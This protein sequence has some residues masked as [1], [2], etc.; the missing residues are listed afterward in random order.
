MAID[1]YMDRRNM[2]LGIYAGLV[3]FTSNIPKSMAQISQQVHPFK[4]KDVNPNSKTDGSL[5]GPQDYKKGLLLLNFA[6][7]WCGPCRREF[8]L[9]EAQ[10][11]MGGLDLLIVNVDDD[12]DWKGM[13]GY[14]DYTYPFLGNP[15][16]AEK[17]GRDI[18][19]LYGVVTSIPVTYVIKDGDVKKI[20]EGSFSKRELDEIIDKYK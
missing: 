15:K 20:Q 10:Y 18:A 16:L 19:E 3:A 4:L 14:D 5:L 17:T 8:P 7:P 9:F 11:K 13:E 6:A 2:L 1:V 12:T